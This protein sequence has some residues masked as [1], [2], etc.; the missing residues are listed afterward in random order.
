[1]NQVKGAV[2]AVVA[3]VIGLV[4]G[5]FIPFGQIAPA[6]TITKTETSTKPTTITETQTQI[7]TVTKMMTETLMTTQRETVTVPAPP[8]KIADI[9]AYFETSRS[10]IYTLGYGETEFLVIRINPYVSRTAWIIVEIAGGPAFGAKVQ[11]Q[12]K[13]HAAL[14]DIFT[15]E[16]SVH[17]YPVYDTY[18]YRTGGPVQLRAGEVI[19]IKV[20]VSNHDEHAG[21]YLVG[22]AEIWDGSWRSAY[23]YSVEEATLA[24]GT[25]SVSTTYFCIRLQS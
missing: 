25:F 21:D 2:V 24:R 22:R 19:E 13:P 12:L 9:T 1:M 23:E 5:F 8:D 6:S 7:N 14:G 17:Q 18:G 11:I 4:I 20:E 15:D 3:L 16:G 10:T